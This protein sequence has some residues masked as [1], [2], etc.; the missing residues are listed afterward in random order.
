MKL[1]F[2]KYVNEDSSGKLHPVPSEFS[3]N[4]IP[5]IKRDLKAAGLDEDDLKDLENHIK[6]T[7]P[8]THYG[9][10]VHKA[11][12]WPSRFK[13]GKKEGR[14]IYI[15]VTLKNAVWI[16]KIYKKNQQKDLSKEELKQILQFA[17]KLKEQ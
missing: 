16:V 14:V 13:Q 6:T 11:E 10:G 17:K 2:E 8:K 4:V 9:F 12:W 3:F 7:L 1:Y 15:E 5:S